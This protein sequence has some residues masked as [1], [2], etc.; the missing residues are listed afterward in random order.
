SHHNRGCQMWKK[1]ARYQAVFGFVAFSAS[2]GIPAQAGT[3]AIATRSLTIQ[4]AGPRQGE[5]GSRYFNVEGVE[6]D[7]DASFGVL[8]FQLPRGEGD[9]EKLSLRLVQSVPRFARDGKVKFLLAEPRDQGTGNL[10]GLKFDPKSPDGL[11]K[12]AFKAIHPLGSGT[13]TKAK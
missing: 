10:A 12:E 9:V 3:E 13:F 4:P 5:A 7:R 2:L 1:L 6:N 8:I 11:G